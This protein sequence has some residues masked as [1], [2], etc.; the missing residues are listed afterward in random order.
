MVLAL[1]INCLLLSCSRSGSLIRLLLALRTSRNRGTRP[2]TLGKRVVSSRRA[3]RKPR[4]TIEDR[5]IAP[6]YMQ[7]PSP[8]VT[9]ARATLRLPTPGS[10][11]T[12]SFRP[13][14]SPLKI[15]TPFWLIR[16]SKP[17]IAC[18]VVPLP[19]FT[20]TG[21]R[22]ARGRRGRSPRTP[23]THTPSPRLARGPGTDPP[24]D[25]PRDDPRPAQAGGGIRI[26]PVGMPEGG[27]LSMVKDA[28]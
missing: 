10:S 20:R 27:E 12:S 13:S 26:V 2:V 23:G 6:R 25:P 9:L 28:T 21:R 17:L 22:R 1:V 4:T 14:T 19:R 15:S 7:V 11:L 8:L 5:Q 16:A 18:P 24:G 3:P